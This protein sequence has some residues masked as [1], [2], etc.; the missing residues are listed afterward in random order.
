MT[1][2]PVTPPS[3]EPPRPYGAE[4]LPVA[5][6]GAYYGQQGYQPPASKTMAGWALGLSILN[7]FSV[8]T[9]VAIGLA[10]AVLVKG[11]RDG[12]NHGR[13][14]AI[15]ALIISSLWIL[16]FVVFFVLTVT[17]RIE[18]DDSRRDPSGE[19]TEEQTISPLSLR[20]GDCVGAGEIVELLREG[21]TE[22]T[23]VPCE[24][25][26]SGEVYSVFDLADGDYP[27]DGEVARLSET[28]C[29][30]AFR[31]FVGVRQARSIFDVTFLHPE[32]LSG[33]PTTGRSCASSARPTS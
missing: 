23:A 15:A 1:V 25:P 12:R 32:G 6:Y 16:A 30:D 14:M 2:P 4:P 11:Q 26:H 27:G 29:V 13:G 31:A 7:C 5:P 10:I 9:L 3:G 33:S 19:L 21:Q 8:G 22:V 17:G 20:E 24:E 28:G 18:F